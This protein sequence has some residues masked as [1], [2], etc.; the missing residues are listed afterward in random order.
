MSYNRDKTVGILTGLICL[1]VVA[2]G[3]LTGIYYA[4]SKLDTMPALLSSAAYLI[5]DIV[6]IWCSYIDYCE[7]N[8]PVEKTAWSI[9]YPLSIYALVMGG[10]ISHSL[11]NEGKQISNIDQA[12]RAQNECLR[13]GGFQTACRKIY[14]TT[15]LSGNQTLSEQ[16]H[17][18]WA[19]KWLVN[20]LFH[21]MPGLLGLIGMIILTAVMK[22]SEKSIET[23]I[24]TSTKFPKH[25]QKLPETSKRF[26]IGFSPGQLKLSPQSSGV[27]IYKDQKYLGHITTAKWDFYQPKTD[28]DILNVLNR[29]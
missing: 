22:L 17:N 29:K 2:G 20:P 23:S 13:N 10:L 19:D 8:T 12:L 9:K 14:E 26:S 24:E 28:D 27:K 11:I 4:F 18:N 6:V 21:Y 7:N 16:S 25:K 1:F 5:L 3:T 15:L